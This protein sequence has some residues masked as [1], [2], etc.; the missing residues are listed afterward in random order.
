MA[1]YLGNE[2]IS[3]APAS[4]IEQ[5]LSQAAYLSGIDVGQNQTLPLNADTLGGKNPEYYLYNDNLLDNSNFLNPVNQR[6]SAS[7]STDGYCIDRW[8]VATG[9]VLNV[10]NHT[11]TGSNT[12]N[13][14]LLYQRL[15]GLTLGRT[16]T[17]SL[18]VNGEIVKATNQLGTDST[19]VW[20][21]FSWGRVA[22]YKDGD[23]STNLIYVNNGTTIIVDWVKLE[24]STVAT[25]YVPKGYGAELA[26]CRRYYQ[27]KT[28]ATGSVTAAT[29]G[30]LTTV[31][32]HYPPMR[33]NPTITY[34][35]GSTVYTTPKGLRV[36]LAG[37]ATLT[38]ISLAGSVGNDLFWYSLSGVSAEILSVQYSLSADL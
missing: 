27:G 16:Y 5:K 19:E 36:I 20:E 14:S 11:L 32:V 24:L 12:S 26:E 37:S 28:E 17:L 10:T 4:P 15:I 6:G 30:K 8:A 25:P 31:R 29:T 23:V 18:K 13:N 38:D 35:N 7:Y 1:L 33:I 9:M 22:V 21:T 2:K 34:Y 3:A